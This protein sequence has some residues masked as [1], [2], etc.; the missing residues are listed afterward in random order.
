MFNDKVMLFSL[1]ASTSVHLATFVSLPDFKSKTGLKTEQYIEVEHFE[2]PK[3][4]VRAKE[5]LKKK[6]TDPFSQEKNRIPTEEKI[7]SDDNILEGIIKKEIE[8][9]YRPGMNLPSYAELLYQIIKYYFYCPD[10]KKGTTEKVRVEFSI[11]RQGRLLSVDIPYG[12]GAKSHKLN[13]AALNAVTIASRH[14]PPLPQCVKKESQL[15][16]VWILVE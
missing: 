2:M 16:K 5:S 8:E 11:S 1:I 3:V 6:D 14:F 4:M 13:I 7:I 15:F 12:A 10:L 9:N